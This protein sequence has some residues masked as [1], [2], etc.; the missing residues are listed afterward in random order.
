[1]AALLVA[2]A[3]VLSHVHHVQDVVAGLAFGV[4]AFLIASVDHGTS[5]GRRGLAVRA[6]PGGQSVERPVTGE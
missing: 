3:R 4:I 6:L 1:M 5:A 2:T